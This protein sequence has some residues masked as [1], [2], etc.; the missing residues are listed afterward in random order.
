M[1]TLG[2]QGATLVTSENVWQADVLVQDGVIQSIGEG[3]PTS[4]EHI[5]DATGLHLFYGVLDP[6]VHFRDPGFTWKED[7]ASGS[8]AAAAGGVTSFFEMPNT[9]P[10]TISREAMAEK[11]K[12]ASEVCLVNYNFFIGATPHNLEELNA[13]ENVCGI[14][15]FMGASTGDLLVSEREQLEPIFKHGSRLIAVHAEDETML[16]ENKKR[17][18]G[19]DPHLHYRIRSAEAALKATQTA[20]EFSQT[21][22]RR[23]H[24]LHLTTRDEVLFLEEA[25]KSAPISVEVCPQ[26]MFLSAPDIYDRLGTFAK[27]NPPLRTKEHADGLWDGLVRGV[28]D[29]IATDHAPHTTEEKEQPF[30]KAPAGMPGVETS[31]PMMLDQVAQGRCSIHDISRWMCEMPYQLYAVKNK[32]YLKE[33]MDAD[34]VLVDLKKTKTIENGRLFTKVNWSPYH[35]MTTT[36]WPIM[37]I[38]NGNIVFRDGEL[39]EGTNGKEVQ[40][41]EVS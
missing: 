34:L 31:F 19:D 6:Q 25:K 2:I 8:R 18:T 37:T 38:V 26:H 3:F 21:Y 11:K 20:V 14:K 39:I 33:G 32:G 1:T 7:L 16:N 4:V 30:S 28:I 13:V 41:G 5:I 10:M 22:Q 15:I 17:Y 29:C 12:H 24:I 40:I 9:R 36:G 35:G 23:L 27:M